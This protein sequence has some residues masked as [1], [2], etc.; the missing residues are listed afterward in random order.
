MAVAHTI[1]ALGAPSVRLPIESYASHVLSAAVHAARL[2][3]KAVVEG[4]AWG[5]AW[6]DE[7]EARLSELCASAPPL[8]CIERAGE[9]ADGE[10]RTMRGEP[11]G[12]VAHGLHALLDRAGRSVAIGD[13]GNELGLGL[14]YEQ[15]CDTIPRGE[16][17]G[18]VRAADAVLV[19]SVSNWGGYALSCAL[20]L[21]AWDSAARSP[22][23]DALGERAFDPSAF[24]ACTVLDTDTGC[25]VI[26]AINE[27][28]AVDGITG[29]GNGEVDGLPLSKQKDVMNELLQIARETMER[30]PRG[31]AFPQG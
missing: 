22:D 27:A 14:L 16:Q 18:C 20:S 19:A 21:L 8:L 3:G 12:R 11:M 13:G 25:A 9:A 7:E 24:L 29:A 2:E 4:F 1:L 10:C 30:S 23:I 28:G 17:I 15:I 31:A 6:G 26:R 5:D